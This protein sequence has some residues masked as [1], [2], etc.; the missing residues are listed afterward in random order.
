MTTTTWQ[1]RAQAKK[2]QQ[3]ES[4][5]KEWVLTS[6][7]DKDQLDVSEFPKTCGLL[8]AREIEITESHVDV[9]LS[10]LAKGTWSAV[11]VTT[12]FSKRAV[13]AHQLVRSYWSS[14][15]FSIADSHMKVNC[16][17]EIFIERAL[18]RAAELDDHFKRTGRIIGPLHG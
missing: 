2:R 13:V 15:T 16:L 17:T 4:I 10:N 8:S 14:F 1:E 11:E 18:A 9:I 7:P 3:L 5:P 6:L 12:A